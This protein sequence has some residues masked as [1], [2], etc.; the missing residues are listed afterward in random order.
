M[1][2]PVDTRWTM[3]ELVDGVPSPSFAY[4][5]AVVEIRRVAQFREDADKNLVGQLV[6]WRLASIL[7]LHIL[8]VVNSE[9]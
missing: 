4:Q 5:Q 9:R 6:D 1:V 7:N 8:D 3:P 2:P